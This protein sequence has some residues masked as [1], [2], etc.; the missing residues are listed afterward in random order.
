MR[1]TLLCLM[2]V[3]VPA[4][5]QSA[6]DDRLK[7]VEHE[8][9][10]ARKSGA[11]LDR[12]AQSLADELAKLQDASV[13]SARIAQEN[14]EQLTDL[15]ARIALLADQEAK[16]QAAL[17]IRQ[18][19]ERQVLGGLQRLAQN[20]PLAILLAPGSPL[21]LARGAMLLGAAVPRLEAE[22][23]D[24]AAALDQLRR[25]R[26]EIAA[27][28]NDLA[29]HQT[30]LDGER[31][32]LS[33]ILRQ[34]QALEGE[35]RERAQAAQ[36]SLALLTAQAG[37]LKELIVR[38]ERER[39]RKL[40]EERHHAAEA[41]A[42]ADRE[43]ADR[44]VKDAEAQRLADAAARDKP[45]PTAAAAVPVPMAAH[46]ALPAGRRPR[47]LEPGKTALQMPAAGDI[48]R[49]FGDAEGF[50]TSKGLTITTRPGARVVAPFDGQIM[51]AGPFKGY[52]QILIIDHGGGYHSLLAGMEQLDASVGQAVIAGEP[53]ATMRLDGTPSLYLE[54]RRQG[55]PINPLPWLAA[56]DGK[57]SG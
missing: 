44:A 20:P 43:A 42:K 5:A 12:Q 50:S 14:E 6:P 52:G 38:V 1:R 36:Q 29:A 10:Q 16:Q 49:R 34:K 24:I 41:K 51:F 40:E 48:A 46:A 54:L 11:D 4:A 8:I 17:Q 15:E 3:A 35:T 39:E 21:D 9:D 27:N 18:E 33:Q 22:A 32:R 2:L 53:L 19:H 45:S 23:R 47:E 56:R 25:T 7:T 28:Q 37:D 13:A 55:Q 57:V 26:A 30:A 31:Q